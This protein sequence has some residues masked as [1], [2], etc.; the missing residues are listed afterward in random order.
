MR[1]CYQMQKRYTDSTKQKHI[2]KG[3]MKY[4]CRR[5]VAVSSSLSYEVNFSIICPFALLEIFSEL[6]QCFH[7]L[8]KNK[9]LEHG[10]GRAYLLR[11]EICALSQ[12]ERRVWLCYSDNHCSQDYFRA[13]SGFL[14]GFRSVCVMAMFT[15]SN[16]L[17]PKWKLSFQSK[18]QQFVSYM[19]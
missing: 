13:T 14:P 4:K 12:I 2:H 19:K 17:I 10:Q 11:T 5:K 16:V 8:T 1:F 3:K 9:I 6:Y 7:F 18:W 15:V